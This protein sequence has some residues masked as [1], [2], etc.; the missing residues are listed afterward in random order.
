MGEAVGEF[1][2]SNPFAASPDGMIGRIQVAV[3]GRQAGE[4]GKEHKSWLC[5][6]EKTSIQVSVS[7]VVRVKR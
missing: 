7:I 6:T 5:S 4:A 1:W 2:V 3:A